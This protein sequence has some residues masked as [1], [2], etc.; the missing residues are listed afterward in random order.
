MKR[1]YLRYRA[2]EANGGVGGH[3]VAMVV[4]DERGPFELDRCGSILISHALGKEGS[5]GQWVN[6][7]V[8]Q[9]LGFV[10]RYET[11]EEVKK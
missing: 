6:P 2:F 8:L 7:L 10:I 9:E 11:V 1:A 4:P 3:D 5:I